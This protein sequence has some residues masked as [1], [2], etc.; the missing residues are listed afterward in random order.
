MSSRKY[1]YRHLLSLLHKHQYFRRPIQQIHAHFLRTDESCGILTLWNSVLKHYSLGAF[2]HEAVVLFKLL[3]GQSNPMDFD[4]FTYAYVIKACA[5]LRQPSVGNQLHCLSIKTGFVGYGVYVQTALVNMYVECGYLVEANKVFGEMPE[6]NLVTWNVLV[7]GFI[8]WGQ[9]ESARAVFDVMPVKNV[10]AW[11]GIIDGY[12]RANRL[13][14]ALS[15]FRRMAVDE[16]IKPT[17]VTLL[18]IFPAIWKSG[19][20]EDCEM[21]HAYGEKSGL[22]ALD[23]RVMN[24]LI[25]A[26]AKVGC[27]DSARQVFEDISDERKNLVSWTSIISGLSMHGMAA[28]VKEFCRGMENELVKPNKITF[29]SVINA[30]SHAGLVDEGLEFYRKMVDDSGIAPDIKHYGSIIDLLGRAGRLEEAEKI[31]LGIP[32]EICN[33]MVWRTLLGA[34]SFHGDVEMGERVA[35]HVMK[36]EME[37]GGDYVLL[38]NIFSGAGRFLDSERVRSVMVERNAAKVPGISLV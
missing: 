32:G 25:D 7:T 12:T 30:C 34:C 31:A 23:I 36:L 35:K 5:N 1:Y 29:L 37:Y 28:E 2:P 11:T 9:I 3:K 20:V 26:Y 6:R 33:V 21:L 15:L 8:K 17:E 22:N 19:C 13:Q 4:S 16:G 38:S 27:I 18:T 14:D 24:C 10:V